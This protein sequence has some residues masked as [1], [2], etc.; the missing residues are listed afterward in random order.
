V[1][2]FL[3]YFHTFVLI[4]F[5]KIIFLLFT[6][7]SFSILVTMMEVEIKEELEGKVKW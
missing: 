2:G 4:S 3:R 5:L 6:N 1:L 7:S